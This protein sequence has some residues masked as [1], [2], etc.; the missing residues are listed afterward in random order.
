MTDRTEALL[1][2]LV[3]LQRKQL[4]N[5]EAAA[6]RQ[7]KAIAMQ[8]QAVERSRRSL[9]GIWLILAVVCGGI[10]LVPLLNYFSRLAR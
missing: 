9:K 6:A 8:A 5:Q 7:E 2:E 10:I 1:A 3:E 4:A